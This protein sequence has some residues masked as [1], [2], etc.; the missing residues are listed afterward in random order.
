MRE[1]R[2]L[3]LLLL[4]VAFAAVADSYFYATVITGNPLFP[5]FNGVFT[6]PYMAAE[7][8]GDQRWHAGVDIRS[9]WDITFATPRYMECYVG[10]A[11]LSLLAFLGA[12]ACSLASR[13]MRA[14][15]T[16]FAFAS[17]LVVF[18]QVQYL[19]YVFPAIALLG[20]L[21]VVAWR[22]FHRRAV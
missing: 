20:T 19:R 13:G 2:Q 12:W 3:V 9:P 16:V 5:F 10:A 21:A 15:L 7:N 14:T 1:Y 17:G 11:G 8:L 6:S 4:V 18:S 22:P